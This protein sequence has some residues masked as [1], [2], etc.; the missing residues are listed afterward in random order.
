MTRTTQYGVGVI[1]AEGIEP[2]PFDVADLLDIGVRCVIL[3]V[4]I[5][6]K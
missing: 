3:I 5:E 1:V 6:P 4:V 2:Q